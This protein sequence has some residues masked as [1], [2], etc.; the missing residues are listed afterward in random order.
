MKIRLHTRSPR[1]LHLVDI[2]NLVGSSQMTPAHVTGVYDRYRAV[3]GI[4]PDDLV[5]I[6]T[7]RRAFL[8]TTGWPSVRRLLRA[9]LHGAD[10]A[11]VDVLATERIAERFD[12]IVIAS[13]DK[14]FAEPAARLQQA[15]CHVTVVSRP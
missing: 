11:L 8:A 2:E 3:V 6:A 10:R 7:G 15:G 13:G 4:G 5:V 14:L 12:E 9:G 1:R